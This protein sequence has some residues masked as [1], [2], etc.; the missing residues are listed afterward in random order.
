MATSFSACV[1]D[2]TRL[3]IASTYQTLP[4]SVLLFSS[5][6]GS[7][8][9]QPLATNATNATNAKMLHSVMVSRLFP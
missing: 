9:E 7:N 1:F 6:E 5:V 8:I 3:H 2:G 4:S